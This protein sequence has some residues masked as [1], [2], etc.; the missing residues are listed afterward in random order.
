M[1]LLSI[2]ALIVIAALIYG[3]IY[4][5]FF[6]IIGVIG[7]R[8]AAFIIIVIAGMKILDFII[9]KG[10]SHRTKI[11]KKVDNKLHTDF[12]EKLFK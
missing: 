1:I 9:D 12:F 4:I 5:F 8:I 6:S 7:M 10:A 3:V 11:W 2:L